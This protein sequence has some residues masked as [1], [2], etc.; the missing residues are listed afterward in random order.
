MAK[1]ELSHGFYAL[2]RFVGKPNKHTEQPPSLMTSQEDANK[3]SIK[4]TGR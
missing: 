2:L 3:A 1:L 4:A